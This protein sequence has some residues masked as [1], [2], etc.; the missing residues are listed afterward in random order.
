MQLIIPTS[1]S[2]VTMA[3][4]SAMEHAK[5]WPGNKIH[6][7]NALV[8]AA[9]GITVKEVD[10]FD[11]KL[12]AS[13]EKDLAW[14]LTYPDALIRE[15]TLDGVEYQLRYDIYAASTGQ[16]ADLT[17]YLK[18]YQETGELTQL[19]YC[20]A[21]MCLPKGEK[22]DGS[23]VEARARLFW[24]KLTIDIAYPYSG[25]FLELWRRLEPII[26]ISLTKRMKEINQMMSET[27]TETVEALS[28]PITSTGNG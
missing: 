17:E 3:K 11:F 2:E 15:F 20:A 8:A 27:L 14:I 18:K 23:K 19:A 25:F 24:D 9:A 16:Y 21:V 4:L 12:I 10:Q 26:K 13:L 22:Y 28:N 6:K 7:H 1:W 5:D